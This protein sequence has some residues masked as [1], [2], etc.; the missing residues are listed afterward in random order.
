MSVKIKFLLPPLAFVRRL[1]YEKRVNRRPIDLAQKDNVERFCGNLQMNEQDYY[2]QDS[3]GE[4]PSGL[5]LSERFDKENDWAD[6][7]S[8]DDEEQDLFINDWNSESHNQ[9]ADSHY[10]KSISDLKTTITKRSNTQESPILFEPILINTKYNFDTDDII[11]EEHVPVPGAYVE[12]PFSEEILPEQGGF[13]NYGLN[14]EIRE[15]LEKEYENDNSFCNF[16]ENRFILPALAQPSRLD[17]QISDSFWNY[18]I[19]PQQRSVKQMIT[20]VAPSFEIPPESQGIWNYNTRT[21]HR[22]NS[23]H[24]YL[25]EEPN[26]TRKTE[27]PSVELLP[28]LM[29]SWNYDQEEEGP[30]SLESLDLEV[31]NY[32]Q[33]ERISNYNNTIHEQTNSERHQASPVFDDLVSTF[34]RNDEPNEIWNY[35]TATS[36]MNAAFRPSTP[37]DFVNIPNIPAYPNEAETVE[38]SEP[39]FKYIITIDVLKARIQALSE[40]GSINI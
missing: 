12:I 32:T 4:D 17:E 10:S 7:D 13:W 22:R 36:D 33:F 38:T 5:L 9:Y 30:S 26:T 27:K 15:S 8:G 3:T 24:H 28:E 21:E 25:N 39:T 31:S 1:R 37:T 34:Y 6:V 14:D 18:P 19:H 40:L 29:G 23:Y 16:S 20:E 35:D 2:R 11:S